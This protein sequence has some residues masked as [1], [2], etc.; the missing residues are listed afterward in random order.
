MEIVQGYWITLVD[1]VPST[2]N[3][4]FMVADVIRRGKKS[5]KLISPII[6]IGKD[7]NWPR[8]KWV[9]E[10]PVPVEIHS[11]LNRIDLTKIDCC[12]IEF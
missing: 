8:N 5:K 3:E 1:V 4:Q 11:I 9:P 7:K 6:V 2:F 12:D 10:Y